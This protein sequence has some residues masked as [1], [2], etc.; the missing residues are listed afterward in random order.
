MAARHLIEFIAAARRK[1]CQVLPGGGMCVYQAAAAFRLFTGIEPDV[2]RM[3]ALF[4]SLSRGRDK[5]A[6]A[7]D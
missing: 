5:A 3:R 1:G 7:D 6:A 4:E 2:S